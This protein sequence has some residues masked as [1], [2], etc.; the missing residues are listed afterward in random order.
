MCGMLLSCLLILSTPLA[1]SL[2]A[3]AK[4]VD[5][6]SGSCLLSQVT[7]LRWKIEEFLLCP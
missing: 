1:S 4:V 3:F 5:A 6:Q 7:V 2:P